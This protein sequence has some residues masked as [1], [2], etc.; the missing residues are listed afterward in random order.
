MSEVEA[1]WAAVSEAANMARGRRI[2]SLF[3]GEPGRCSRLTLAAAGLEIDLSKQPWSRD[4]RRLLIDLARIGGVEAARDRL[5]AGHIAN[6]SEGRPA[7][8][9]A[10]RAPDGADWRAAGEPVSRLIEATRTAMRTRK[11]P[12]YW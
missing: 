10:L 9:M 11:Y 6:A 5:F 8:H 7:L 1:T 2:D 12:L 4:D 3:A